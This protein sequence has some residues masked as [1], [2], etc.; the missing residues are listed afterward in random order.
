MPP[1]KFEALPYQYVLRMAEK[2]QLEFSM[3]TSPKVLYYRLSTPAGL[4]EWFADDVNSRG[5][6]FTFFWD[7]AEE[8]ARVLAKKENQFVRFQWINE[9]LSP[10]EEDCYFEFRISS[11]ELTGEV[12]LL[13]TDHVE[14]EQDKSDAIDLW[15]KQV[16]TLKHTL[17][18]L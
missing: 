12:S 6:N 13:I 17:G 9:D 2:Y 11:E 14:T 5:D 3:N 8:Q 15:E 7:G 16:S 4:S 18:I 1:R 10:V